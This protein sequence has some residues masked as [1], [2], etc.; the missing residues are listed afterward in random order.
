[1]IW[2]NS[3]WTTPNTTFSHF[4][5]RYETPGL[6]ASM[7]DLPDKVKEVKVRAIGAKGVSSA[8]PPS[9]RMIHAAALE[10]RLNDQLREVREVSMI[11]EKIASCELF[12][13]M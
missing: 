11:G 12:A 2:D 5:Y 6:L 10:K 4:D 3:D 1:M 9:S 8:H 13:E 7:W